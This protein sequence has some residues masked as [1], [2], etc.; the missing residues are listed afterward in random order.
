MTVFYCLWAVWPRKSIWSWRRTFPLLTYRME[1][2]ISGILTNSLLRGFTNFLWYFFPCYPSWPITI[3]SNLI[4]HLLSQSSPSIWRRG[5]SGGGEPSVAWR[6]VGRRLSPPLRRKG[7]RHRLLRADVEG[8]VEE[9]IRRTSELRQ[10]A[11]GSDADEIRKRESERC[12]WHGRV[13]FSR[14]VLTK[15]D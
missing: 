3:I 15:R 11:R 5:R 9:K 2:G 13:I 6:A 4:F 10:H 12:Q 8:G 1:K 14:L 7:G